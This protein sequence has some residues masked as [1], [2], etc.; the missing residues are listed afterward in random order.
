MGD[1]GDRVGDVLCALLVR[2]SRIV[3]QGDVVLS[4]Q[5]ALTLQAAQDRYSER[6]ENKSSSAAVGVKIGSEGMGFSASGSAGRGRGD[7]DDVVHPSST[8]K[9]RFCV[10]GEAASI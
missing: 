3:A 4:A 9:R 8:P 6:S 7:G 5:D 1:I 10:F 2:G